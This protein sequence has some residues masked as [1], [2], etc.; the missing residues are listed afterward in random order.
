MKY[1]TCPMNISSEAI[2]CCPNSGQYYHPIKQSNTHFSIL[3]P[4]DSRYQAHEQWIFFLIKVP[5]TVEIVF[6]FAFKN[7]HSPKHGN[8]KLWLFK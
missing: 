6:S 7:T 2:C 3:D 5:D 1:A 8:H 4:S